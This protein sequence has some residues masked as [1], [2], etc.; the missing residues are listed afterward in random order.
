MIWLG[1]HFGW[2]ELGRDLA[3][4]SVVVC[5]LGFAG[6]GWARHLVGLEI[7]LGWKLGWLCW[8]FGKLG[9]MVGSKM[10]LGVRFGWVLH[11]FGLVWRFG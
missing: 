5:R 8:T 3:G 2:A 7:W 4:D 1:W 11:L 9:A 10:W 6:L